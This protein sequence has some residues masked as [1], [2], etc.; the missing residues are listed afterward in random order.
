MHGYADGRLW[1]A[2]GMAALLSPY[3]NYIMTRQK[4]R[5]LKSEL[6]GHP[7]AL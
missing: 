6:T 4:A 5:A 7:L 1:G 2:H 3:A